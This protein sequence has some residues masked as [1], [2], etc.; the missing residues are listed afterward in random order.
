[1]K[2]PRKNAV[3]CISPRTFVDIVKSSE[4][5]LFSWEPPSYNV[6]P[7]SHILQMFEYKFATIKN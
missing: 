7:T 5:I 4:L 3:L 2:V 6:P 1:M